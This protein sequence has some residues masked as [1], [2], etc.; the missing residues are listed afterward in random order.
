[1]SFAA[2]LR[3]APGR[4][5]TGAFILEQGLGKLQADDET[6]KHLHDAATSAYPVFEKLDPKT[7]TK[8][9]GTGETALGTALLLPLVP[10]RFAGLGLA[11]FAGGL[12]GLWW[13]TPSMHEPNSP[14]PTP[15][16]VPIAKDSW[17]LAIGAGLVVD[18]LTARGSERRVARKAE[19]RARRQ[20]ERE[21]SAE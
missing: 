20:A 10:A 4:V 15:Q 17:M 11:G 21:A 7:F 12:L 5:A 8:L 2:K 9:L 13:R 16:G 6:A 1:M 3:R 18:A 14:R 19:R